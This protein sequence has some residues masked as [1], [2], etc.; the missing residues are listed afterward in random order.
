MRIDCSVGLP[1]GYEVDSD[2]LQIAKQKAENSGAIIEQI[3]DP[4]T[5]TDNVGVIYTNVWTSMG[6]EGEENDR[7]EAFTHYQVNDELVKYAK[8]DF[9]LPLSPCKP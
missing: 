9:F 8:N 6:S 7:L 5:A 1:E 2:I 4:K 3:N